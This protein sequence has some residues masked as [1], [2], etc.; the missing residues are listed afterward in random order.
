MSS[1]KNC[2]SDDRTKRIL[3][4]CIEKYGI[5][6]TKA[7]E[8]SCKGTP[9]SD[10][11]R[12]EWLRTVNPPYITKSVTAFTEVCSPILA[13]DLAEAITFLAD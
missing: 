10:L 8:C 2:E 13:N 1:Q 11:A 9:Q 7:P 3:Y 6:N 5:E 12:A 4:E